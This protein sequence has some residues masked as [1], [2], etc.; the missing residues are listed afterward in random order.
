[1]AKQYN[2]PPNWP[3]PPEGWTPPSEDWQAD[4]SWGPPPPGWKLWADEKPK[5]NKAAGGCLGIIVLLLLIAGYNA[6]FNSDDSTKDIATAVAT[7]APT[8]TVTVTAEVA[9]P[10]T[11]KTVTAKPAGP[12]DTIDEGQWEVGADVKAGRYKLIDRVSEMCYWAVT[13]VGKPD[14]IIDNGLPTGGRP[15]VTLRKGQEFTNQ[16]CGTWGRL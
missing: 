11:T 7:S 6:L 2:S 13:P 1:M 3:K 10:V 14:S 12:K 16:G 15:T 4:P 8:P 9:G 5:D